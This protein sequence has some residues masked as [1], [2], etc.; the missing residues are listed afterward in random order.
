MFFSLYNSY[1]KIKGI[2]MRVT[3]LED[4]DRNEL[5]SKVNNFLGQIL[6]SQIKEIQYRPVSTEGKE[7]MYTVLVISSDS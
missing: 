6:E 3:V 7:I 1:I 4:T 5:S 2:K